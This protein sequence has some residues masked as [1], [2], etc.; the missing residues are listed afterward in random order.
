MAAEAGLTS[1]LCRALP[2]G[3]RQ[4]SC[5]VRFRLR[6]AEPVQ[7]LDVLTGITE[8]SYNT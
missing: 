5:G 1:R 7:R 4:P 6:L 8:Q 2:G 3:S